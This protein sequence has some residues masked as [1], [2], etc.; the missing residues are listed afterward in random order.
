MVHSRA[1]WGL[2]QRETKGWCEDI[3]IYI[4]IY[5]HISSEI[6]PRIRND[7]SNVDFHRA[8][9]TADRIVAC[10]IRVSAAFEMVPLH[11]GAS[12]ISFSGLILFEAVA[13]KS[14]LDVS[15]ALQ[16]YSLFKIDHCSRSHCRF[17]PIYL[18]KRFQMQFRY[19]E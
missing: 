4:K 16:I 9:S 8:K 17:P 7:R 13:W 10:V 14:F 15:T 12:V 18:F 11:S 2:D 19:S 3:Y 1:G 6:T 5:I